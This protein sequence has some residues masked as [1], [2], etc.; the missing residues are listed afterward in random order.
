MQAKADTFS[1]LECIDK[2]LEEL[3]EVTVEAKILAEL[4][5]QGR[6]EETLQEAR[7][8]LYKEMSD[9][10]TTGIETWKPLDPKAQWIFTQKYHQ[11]I[12]VDIPDAIERKL[13]GASDAKAS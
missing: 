9:V 10:N 4:I 3:R 12:L 1:E 2:F 6:G 5:M 11:A 8:R 13:N 7:A